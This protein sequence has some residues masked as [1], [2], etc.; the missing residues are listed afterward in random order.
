MDNIE[1]TTNNFRP[2]Q[3]P[4]NFKI[5][6]PCTHYAKSLIHYVEIK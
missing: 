6:K 2:Q 1:F 4:E 5:L 3:K